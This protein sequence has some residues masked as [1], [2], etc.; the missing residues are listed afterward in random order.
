[1]RSFNGKVASRLSQVRHA[2]L[3]KGIGQER[4]G[5]TQ[6]SMLVVRLRHA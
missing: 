6:D 4:R 3:F 1:M 2:E 5:N